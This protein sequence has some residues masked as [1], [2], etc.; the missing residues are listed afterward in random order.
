[1]SKNTGVH[2]IVSGRVQGVFFRIET[3]NAAK[4]FNVSGWVKN[5]PDGT[6]EAVFEGAEAD[7][8]SVLQWCRKGPPMARVKGIET[9]WKD[10]TGEFDRFEIKG[11]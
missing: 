5:R 1:M 2:V 11:W 7:V 9:E 4:R 10:H 8:E 3:K 6:V